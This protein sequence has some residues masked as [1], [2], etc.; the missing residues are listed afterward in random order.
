MPATSNSTRLTGDGMGAWGTGTFENDSALDW[1]DDLGAQGA[2]AVSDLIEEI[3]ASDYIESDM[4]SAL[5]VAGEAVAYA[6]G[7]GADEL[8]ED[9]A[10]VFDA[11]QDALK[12]HSGKVLADAIIRATS[13]AESSELVELWE[14]AESEDHQAWQASVEDLLD[15]L[16]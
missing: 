5:L 1:L 9:H 12:K 3:A 4:A 16:K 6:Q 14:E 2:S 10:S 11:H 13:S 8:D 15:R 7:N